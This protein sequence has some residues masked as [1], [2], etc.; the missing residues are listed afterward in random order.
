MILRV[1]RDVKNIMNY[2]NNVNNTETS[3]YHDYVSKELHLHRNLKG[4]LESLEH[5]FDMF[6][7]N[8]IDGNK[9]NT[10]LC[11]KNTFTFFFL[12]RFFYKIFLHGLSYYRYSYRYINVITNVTYVL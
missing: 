12:H 10:I 1:L 4:M 6:G 5:N 11:I 7:K 8:S 2:Y 3:D 9:Y